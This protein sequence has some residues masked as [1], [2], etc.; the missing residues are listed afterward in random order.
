MKGKST[1][2]FSKI[3]NWITSVFFWA[4]AVLFLILIISCSLFLSELDYTYYGSDAVSGWATI[5]SLF[6]ALAGWYLGII[7]LAVCWVVFAFGAA[8][9]IVGIVFHVKYGRSRDPRNIR[10]GLLVKNI[11]LSIL[12]LSG[13]SFMSGLLEEPALL[14]IYFGIAALTV[15]SWVAFGKVQGI[16]TRNRFF[17]SACN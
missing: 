9:G 6:G 1:M 13:L 14:L 2:T 3:M 5:L 11:F 17:D 8:P 16:V 4:I 15:L 10:T 7:V 12:T